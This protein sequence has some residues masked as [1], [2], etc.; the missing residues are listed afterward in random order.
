M[1]IPLFPLNV[2]LFPGSKLP[3][4]IFEERYKSMINDCIQ[5]DKIFGMN[6]MSEKNLHSTGCTATVSKV[7][8][9]SPNGELDIE[10]TGVNRF[11]LRKYDLNSN[12][13]FIGDIEML[14]DNNIFTNENNF[15]HAVEEYNKLIDITSHGLLGKIDPLDVKWRN[16]KNSVSFFISQ[17][18]GLTIQERQMMLEI[19]TENERLKYLVN[20]FDK[21]MPKIAEADRIATI[22]KNDGYLQ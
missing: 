1:Q 20:Y 9:R 14:E 16:G 10:I 18:C 6:Y 3:L 11:F 13:Y 5:D 22:I 17:K 2:V 19:N 12:G 21:L 15:E 4:H 7:V 8:K